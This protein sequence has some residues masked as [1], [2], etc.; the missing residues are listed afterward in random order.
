[1]DY[2]IKLARNTPTDNES[3]CVLKEEK[4]WFCREQVWGINKGKHGNT[5]ELSKYS[6]LIFT[7]ED[8]TN[9]P[10][11]AVNEKPKGMEKPPEISNTGEVLSRLLE[12]C[13]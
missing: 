12:L 10:E 4:I 1:M 3:F 6:A 7:V 9:S 11:T 13:I 5:D 2:E 8:A